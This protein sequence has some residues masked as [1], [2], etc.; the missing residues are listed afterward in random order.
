MSI[1]EV[2]S[3]K[4]HFH[5]NSGNYLLLS[6][7]MW[8]WRQHPCTNNER[9]WRESWWN[10]P[11]FLYTEFSARRF[12]SLVKSIDAVRDWICAQALPY[13][14]RGDLT[15]RNFLANEVFPSGGVCFYARNGVL[16]EQAL[17]SALVVRR[18]KEGE[19]AALPLR[20]REEKSLRH[21]AVVEKVLDDNK[22]K[23]S[24]KRWIRFATNFIDLIQFYLIWEIFASFSQVES[25]K[26]VSKFRKRKKQLSCCVHLLHKAWVWN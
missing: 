17:R 20:D 25:E 23:K 5:V 2:V 9:S 14:F 7:K 18:A 13:F 19:L 21:F 11:W 3:S 4:F 26:T 10:K 22:P 1:Q 16:C 6:T 12:W 8:I 24:L 15:V